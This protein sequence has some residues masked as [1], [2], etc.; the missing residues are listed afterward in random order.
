MTLIR[1]AD[2]DV[3]EN[4]LV[5]HSPVPPLQWP[6]PGKRKPDVLYATTYFGLVYRLPL[7]GFADML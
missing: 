7:F 4:R 1:A 5:M 6:Q 2:P 3:S